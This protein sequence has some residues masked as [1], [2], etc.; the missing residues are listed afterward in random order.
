[1]NTRVKI[2]YSDGSRSRY[3]YA[4]DEHAASSYGQPVI[5]LG[6]EALGA[7][8]LALPGGTIVTSDTAL[9]DKL[10]RAGYPVRVSR[11]QDK[12]DKDNVRRV[13]VVLGLS[14][15]DALAAYCQRECIAINAAI[16]RAIAREVNQNVKK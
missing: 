3:A 16:K 1:M 8:D 7:G 14:E 2:E 13:T 15:Y 12:W 11:P 4:T 10:R 5:V 6:D 9:A